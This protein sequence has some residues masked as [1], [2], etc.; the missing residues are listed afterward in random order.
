MTGTVTN[1]GSDETIQ[2]L[3]MTV[4]ADVVQAKRIDL[5]PGESTDVSFEYT[6]ETDGEYSVAV[7]DRGPWTITVPELE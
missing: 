4:D 6:F 1:T 2:V 3:K 7:E 5:L